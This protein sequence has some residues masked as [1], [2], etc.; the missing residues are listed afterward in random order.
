MIT[1]L[2]SHFLEISNKVIPLNYE[3]LL[4]N[5]EYIE[6]LKTYITVFKFYRDISLEINDQSKE[7]K[8]QI[9]HNLN[10]GT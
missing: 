2:S 3:S 8:Q 1:N 7:L 4:K 10:K 5:R 6:S 9:E